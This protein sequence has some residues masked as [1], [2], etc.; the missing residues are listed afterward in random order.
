MN[1]NY[2][3]NGRNFEEL[4]RTISLEEAPASVQYFKNN[5]LQKPRSKTRS[6]GNEKE[7]A[8]KLI[9]EKADRIKIDII[10][11][12]KIEVRFY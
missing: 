12:Q 11:E 3:L 2:S 10:E 4:K 7:F 9:Q 6:I 5:F 1:F 8:L